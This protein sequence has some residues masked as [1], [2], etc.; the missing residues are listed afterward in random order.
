MTSQIDRYFFRTYEES[1]EAFRQRLSEIRSRWPAAKLI[2][3]YLRDHVDLSIDWIY[4]PPT[5]VSAKLLVITTGEH[6]I[7]GFIGSAVLQLLFD[8]YVPLFD[9]QGT[10]LLI[11]HPINPW[12][13]KHRRRS[14]SHNVDLNRNFWDGD[15]PPANGTH[16][17]YPRLRRLLCPSSPVHRLLRRNVAFG[18]ELLRTLVQVGMDRLQVATLVGQYRDSKSILYGGTHIQE[19]TQVLM[20]LFHNHLPGYQE[21]LVLDMHSGYGKRGTMSLVNSRAEPR[22][23]AELSLR[24]G[25]DNVVASD[26]N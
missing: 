19:E 20:D 10:G 13:M 24:F 2:S 9:P 23:S 7:E 6:G 5:T 16:A 15:S 1:R 4:A 12:G 17:D 18:V 25:Y 11:V 21:I 3:H 22:T 8:K 14:N 26:S